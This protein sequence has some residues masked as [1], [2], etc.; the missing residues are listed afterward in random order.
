[1]F[2]VDV[3]PLKTRDLTPPQSA[4]ASKE[5]CESV[6]LFHGGGG[7]GDLLDR[8]HWSLWILML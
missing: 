2:Y 3:L 7:T 5:D 6:G 8:C 4:I 1:M